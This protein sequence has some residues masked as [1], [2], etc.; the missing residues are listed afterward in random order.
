MPIFGIGIANKFGKCWHCHLPKW[1]NITFIDNIISNLFLV[2]KI[3]QQKWHFDILKSN[4]FQPVVPKPKPGVAGTNNKFALP[5]EI[6]AVSEDE[7]VATFNYEEATTDE[8]E[9]EVNGEND[10]TEIVPEAPKQQ[11]AMVKSGNG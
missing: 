6:S 5:A 1:P 7:S 4:F 9:E 8:M 11:K 3:T 10:S 2:D